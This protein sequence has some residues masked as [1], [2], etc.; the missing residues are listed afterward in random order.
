VT[1]ALPPPLPLEPAGSESSG[2]DDKVDI[3]SASPGADS[4][5]TEAILLKPQEQALLCSLR[6]ESLLKGIKCNSNTGK[7][8]RAELVSHKS[9]PHSLI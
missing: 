6:E 9:M 1:L 4:V 5:S 2:D 8:N 7:V 3:G